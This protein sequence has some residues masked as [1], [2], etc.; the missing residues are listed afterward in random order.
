MSTVKQISPSLMCCD[1]FDFENQMNIFEEMGI[2]YLH[3]D[4]MDGTFV[5]NFTLGTDFI[6]QVKSKT[7]IPVDLH[8]MI[9]HPETKLD[10]FEFGENDVVSV[11]VES[12]QHLQL[13]VQRIKAR[14]AKAFVAIN[15]ATPICILEEALEDID[16]VL[17]MT[18]NPGFA[19]QKLVPST[20]KK[21]Q[22]LR[23]YLDKNK[24]VD[25][26]IEVDGNVSFI[27]A[28][29]MSKAGAN[30]F[31]TGTSSVFNGDLKGSIKKLRNCIK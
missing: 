26:L 23:E 10:F 15:P 18:V 13:A 9:N 20:L 11:H 27:N 17:V 29:L 8:L 31:V 4:V 22:K 2:E 16:G 3:I 14:G 19:G 25:V 21:I 12:T 24:K 7:K 30:I 5:P 28:E 6:K 1:F